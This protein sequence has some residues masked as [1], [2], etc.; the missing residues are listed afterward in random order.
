MGP[1]YM[2]EHCYYVYILANTFHRLYTGVTND[3]EVR[4]RQHKDKVHPES[5]AA[6]YGIDKLVY[7]ERFQL[8][9][10]AIA[11]EKQIKGWLRV[12]KLALV[13]GRNPTWLDLSVE[14]GKAIEPFDEAKMRVPERF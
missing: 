7:F 5:F 1:S 8:I 12:K 3:L 13:V 10:A 2:R 14:W 9:D 6:R 11:R 4:V